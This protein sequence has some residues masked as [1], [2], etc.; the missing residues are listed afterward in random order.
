MLRDAIEKPGD[1]SPQSLREEYDD[2]LAGTIED[3][4][5]EGAAALTNLD[6]ETLAALLNGEGPDITLEAAT[7]ILALDESRPDAETLEAEA[8]DI[9]LMGMSIAVLDVEAVAAGID[10]ELEPKEIQQK[11]EGRYPLTVD[12]Y[13]LLHAFIE[14]RKR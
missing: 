4:G 8:R 3:V 13:A 2:L 1:H 5:L 10:D 6:E 14:S 12:E 11:I 7:A 9:L